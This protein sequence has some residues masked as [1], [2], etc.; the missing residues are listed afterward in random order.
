MHA[1]GSSRAS[2]SSKEAPAR[3]GTAR[4]TLLALAGLLAVSGAA[5]AFC[6]ARGYCLYYGDATAHVNIARRLIDSRTPGWDQIGTVWLPL[7]HLLMLP[8]VR[9]DRL[10]QS[11]LAGAI[12]AAGKGMLHLISPTTG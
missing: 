11:G 5:L 8:L 7:P 1:T 12:P 6:A 3:P 2:L 9:T 4:A 10:W